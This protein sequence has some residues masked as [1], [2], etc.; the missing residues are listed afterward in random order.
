MI[1]LRTKDSHKGYS[2]NK[3]SHE[4]YVYQR[5]T[6]IKDMSITIERPLG[7]VNLLFD[8]QIQWL[9]TLLKRDD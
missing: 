3:M 5:I 6:N 4:G 1:Y 9:R 2:F 8:F 7:C